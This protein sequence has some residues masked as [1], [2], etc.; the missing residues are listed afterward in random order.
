MEWGKFIANIVVW[1][2]LKQKSHVKYNLLSYLLS[3][4]MTI[5]GFF[6]L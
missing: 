1:K 5:F 4:K 6:D 3:W 2:A